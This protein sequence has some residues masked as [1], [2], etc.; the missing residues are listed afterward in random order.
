MAEDRAFARKKALG[1]LF[2][3]YRTELGNIRVVEY[4]AIETTMRYGLKILGCNRDLEEIEQVQMRASL[5]RSLQPHSIP[6]RRNKP[7]TTS[8]SS[9]IFVSHA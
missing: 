1:A 3:R 5:V 8:H 4:M 2:H 9:A 6:Q 7:V